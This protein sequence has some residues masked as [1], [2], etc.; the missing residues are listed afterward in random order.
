MALVAVASTV[1]IVGGFY[2]YNLVLFYFLSGYVGSFNT[3]VL[4]IESALTVGLKNNYLTSQTLSQALAMNCPEAHNWPN[5]RFGTVFGK[6]FI[7]TH[8]HYHNNS[9]KSDQYLKIVSPLLQMGYLRDMSLVPIIKH[10]TKNLDGFESFA[11]NFF[12]SNPFYPLVTDLSNNNAEGIV[13]G[14]GVYAISPETNERYHDTHGTTSFS[15]HNILTPVLEIFERDS[16]SSVM[17]NLH[18]EYHR[19]KAIDEVIDAWDI[20]IRNKSAVTSMVQ[21]VQDTRQRPA[22]MLFYPISPAS[23]NSELAGFVRSVHDWDTVLREA[24]PSDS[25]SVQI[26][27]NDGIQQVTFT[28]SSDSVHF[29]G[30][31]DR[32]DRAYDQFSKSYRHRDLSVGYHR[33]T[34]NIYPSAEYFPSSV[35]VISSLTCGAVVLF[36]LLLTGAFLVHDAHLQGQLWEKQEALSLKQ[37]FV[38]F[39]SHE[40]RTP[41][42]T[43]CIGL[44]LL[45]DEV[46]IVLT[47]LQRELERRRVEPE[48]Q[49]EMVTIEELPPMPE[50]SI[51]DNASSA[52]E[53]KADSDENP[54][55]PSSAKIVTDLAAKIDFWYQLIR[56]VEESSVNA[57]SILNELLSYDKIEQKTMTI[58][59]EL[60]PVWEVIDN[61]IKPLSIQARYSYTYLPTYFRI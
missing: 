19:A 34:F 25:A 31:G 22:S 5:C 47:D 8:N 6:V 61:A 26:V 46:N 32:H 35:T 7:L 43:V 56:E 17:F 29:V 60:L 49:L 48:Q 44:K 4:Q 38:R 45:L 52:G 30:W 2:V 11:Y 10:P 39:I 40:I 36:V 57:V 15:K 23:N 28:V 59:K 9:V 41:M 53:S 13:Y 58:E 55:V 51:N 18:S 27:I 3:L 16:M 24:V 50:V 12:K 37:S 21:L 20:G 33:F 1:M 54:M 42:N 14:G